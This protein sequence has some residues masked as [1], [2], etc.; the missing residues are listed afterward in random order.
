[1]KW[2]TTSNVLAVFFVLIFEGCSPT[3]DSMPVISS[4]TVQNIQQTLEMPPLNVNATATIYLLPSPT[5][6]PMVSSTNGKQILTEFLQSNGECQLPC[7]L[8][9]TPGGYIEEV[10]NLI[11]FFDRGASNVVNER[12]VWRCTAIWIASFAKAPAVHQP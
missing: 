11:D 3:N 4:S 6:L 5:T 10:Q 1:M 9:L 7:L 12:I 8:G 2:S